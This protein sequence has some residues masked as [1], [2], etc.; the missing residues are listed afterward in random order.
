MQPLIRSIFT[1]FIADGSRL[2]L[3]GLCYASPATREAMSC[4]DLVPQ[5]VRNA[6]FCG[7]LTG[8]SSGTIVLGLGIL[9]KLRI[10]GSNEYT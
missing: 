9:N 7:G 4:G 3:A 8:L 2:V 10:L 6:G 5:S 1:G